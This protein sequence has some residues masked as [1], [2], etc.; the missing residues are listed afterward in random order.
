[1]M[2]IKLLNEG[3]G[4]DPDQTQ[5][6]AASDLSGCLLL[7]CL[8]AAGCMAYSADHDQTLQNEDQILVCAPL[9]KHTYSNILKILPQ[10]N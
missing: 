2:S 1:M 3:K 7:I 8:N 6:S 5:R 9:R 4:V 10:K